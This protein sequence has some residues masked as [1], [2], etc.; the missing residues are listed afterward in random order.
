MNIVSFR[1]A[2][3]AVLAFACPPL[4]AHPGHGDAF[5]DGLFHP[6]AGIDH[7]LATLAVGLW[8]AGEEEREFARLCAVHRQLANNPNLRCEYKKHA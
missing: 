2:A 4:F 5:I 6:Y 8:A 1:I 3:A 7:L